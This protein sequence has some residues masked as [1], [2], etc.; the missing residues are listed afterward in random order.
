MEKRLEDAELHGKPIQPWEAFGFSMEAEAL[1][2]YTK[3]V[4]GSK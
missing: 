4:E 2:D 1:L 3:A